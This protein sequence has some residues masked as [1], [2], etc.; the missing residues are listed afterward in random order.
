LRV[1]GFAPRHLSRSAKS[2]TSEESRRH[3][4]ED[5]RRRTFPRG[6]DNHGNG[7]QWDVSGQRTGEQKGAFSAQRISFANGKLSFHMV[8]SP[9]PDPN[10]ANSNE[11]SSVTVSGGILIFIHKWGSVTLQ[12]VM[13]GIN[14]LN[15]SSKQFPLS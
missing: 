11:I 3:L 9:K 8:I 5:I 4:G 1:F 6:L 10:W 15:L 14:L 2:L 12:R 13:P 7:S